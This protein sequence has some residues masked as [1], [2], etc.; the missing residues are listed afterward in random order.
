[1]DKNTDGI[2]IARM[3]GLIAQISLYL[4]ATHKL[5]I[6]KGIYTE[7]EFCDFL[8]KAEKENEETKTIKQVLSIVKNLSNSEIEKE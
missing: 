7:N 2:T 4:T 3:I 1:M 6:E 5:L 8:D